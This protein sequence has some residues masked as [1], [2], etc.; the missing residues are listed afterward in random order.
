MERFNKKLKPDKLEKKRLNLKKTYNVSKS[1][2]SMP[3]LSFV[4]QFASQDKDYGEIA[5]DLINEEQ[6]IN[7]KDNNGDLPLVYAIKS[8]KFNL[9]KM[10]LEKDVNINNTNKEGINAIYLAIAE[11]H[12]DEE[13]IRLLYRNGANV[14]NK[15]E[16]NKSAF[17]LIKECMILE[18]Q[19]NLD[20]R[21]VKMDII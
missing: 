18:D 4:L 1:Y 12:P 7:D 11:D 6:D 15:D 2:K 13:T 19:D 8:K 21:N 14:F 3:F 17:D 16:T 9:I 20:K 10:L 5:K